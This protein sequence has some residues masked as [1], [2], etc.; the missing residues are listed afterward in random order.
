MLKFIVQK[1]RSESDTSKWW[2]RK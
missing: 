1:D 2:S